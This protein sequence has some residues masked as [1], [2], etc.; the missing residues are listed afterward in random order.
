VY[1]VIAVVGPTGI[2][3]DEIVYSINERLNFP[4]LIVDSMKV[5]RLMNT[6]TSKPGEYF[7]AKFIHFGLDIR[8]HWEGFNAGEFYEYAKGI[9]GKFNYIIAVAG[10]PMYLTCLLRGIFQQKVETAGIRERLEKE[11]E[12]NGLEVLYERLKKEDFEYACKISCKDKK[13]IIR[14]LEVIE[15]TGKPFSQYHIHF[16][17][18]FQYKTLVIGIEEEKEVLK[19]LIY[20]RTKEIIKKGIIDEVKFLLRIAPFSLQSKEAIGYKDTLEFLKKG[21]TIEKLQESI[22]KNTLRYVKHQNSWFRKMVKVKIKKE[23]SSVA[24]AYEDI[25]KFLNE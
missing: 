6:G 12:D 16:K 19:K 15:A 14:A 24:Q 13:R 18:E 20:E 3:K 22:V 2:N 4:V 21:T 7:R 11:A 5:Y 23:V 10:T 8:N 25:Q 9:L 1:K 17:K